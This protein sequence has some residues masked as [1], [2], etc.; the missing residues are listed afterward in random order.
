MTII[1]VM[2]L[3]MQQAGKTVI[4][5]VLGSNLRWHASYPI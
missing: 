1:S 4:Q 2:L 5:E 3:I